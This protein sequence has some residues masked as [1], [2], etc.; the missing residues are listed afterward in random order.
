MSQAGRAVSSRVLETGSGIGKVTVMRVFVAGGAG[1]LA[2]RALALVDPDGGGTAAEG[3]LRLA[4][5]LAE[6]AALAAP[7]D[8]GVHRVRAEVFARLAGAATSTMAK[9]V[10]TWTS[11]QSR[12]RADEDG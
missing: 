12:A 10:F 8:A 6:L 2:E 1:V 5:H 7:A 3:S 4:G 9:G 11:R